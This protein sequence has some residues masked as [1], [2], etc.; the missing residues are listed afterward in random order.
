MFIKLATYAPYGLWVM[1]NGH[2]WAKR[3]LATAGIG[4]T[5]LDNGLW[6]V[7]DPEAARRICAS[8]GSGHVRGL[9]DRWLPSLPSPLTAADRRAG[10]DWAWSVR[11]IEI[12][13]TAVFDRPAAGG[14]G[15]R[16]RSVTTLISAVPTR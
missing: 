12:A 2:E 10:F 16:R 6:T 7:D 8:L 11:Q 14:P 1:A 13:D 15:L 4:F 9:I 3:R 5:E